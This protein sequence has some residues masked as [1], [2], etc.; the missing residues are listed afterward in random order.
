MTFGEP[1]A[2]RDARAR[3]A[4]KVGIELTDGRWAPTKFRRQQDEMRANQ[5][6]QRQTNAK[7][8]YTIF[9]VMAGVMVIPLLLISMIGGMDFFACLFIVIVIFTIVAVI[10]AVIYASSNLDFVA[11][12][13][14]KGLYPVVETKGTRL[15]LDNGP[16][17]YSKVSVCQ[18][19]RG[20]EEFRIIWKDWKRQ[21][22]L[23]KQYEW[24]DTLASALKAVFEANGIPV[25]ETLFTFYDPQS[26]REISHGSA[27]SAQTETTIEQRRKIVS[28]QAT[29]AEERQRQLDEQRSK[30]VVK[31]V[32][33]TMDE[34]I[35][36][37]EVV[38][39]T[40]LDRPKPRTVPTAKGPVTSAKPGAF[41]RKC[42][43]KI[44]EDLIECPR[45]GTAL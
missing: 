9:V 8:F 17:D 5:E 21:V 7:T 32:E 41:C 43:A 40:E 31:T 45:C 37:T 44:D 30:E 42:G 24:P 36:R 22:I 39:R 20:H 33:A 2:G 38:L 4:N 14:L 1:S 28:A 35:A 16:V 15:F 13:N 12:Q 27:V 23:Y 3:V 6:R 19:D 29:L 10:M 11:I 34:D 25:E 18:L 26:I